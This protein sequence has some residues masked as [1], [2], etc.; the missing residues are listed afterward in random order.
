MATHTNI[1]ELFDD[2]ALELQKQKGSSAKIV[3]DTFPTVISQLPVAMKYEVGATTVRYDA[4]HTENIASNDN[5]RVWGNDEK[6]Y[7]LA[8]WNAIF[9]AAGYDK[10]QMPTSPKGYAFRKMNQ[11]WE[12][13]SWADFFT[14]QLWRLDGSAAQDDKGLQHSPY[15]TL[16]CITAADSGTDVMTNKDWS[17]TADG[18]EWVL[19]AAATKQSFRI[20]KDI[21]YVNALGDSDDFE[22]RTE[23]LYQISEWY[24]HR[25]AIT[26][27]LTTTA[28]NGT[29]GQIAIFN[30]GGEQAAAGEDMYFWIRATDADPWV[31]SEIKAQYNVNNLHKGNATSGL[32]AAYQAT[33]YGA[34][35]TAGID[36]NDTGVNSASKP[37]LA[38]GMKGAEAI[39]VDGYWYIITPYVTYAS[40]ATYQL[41][42]SPAVYWIR[43]KGLSLPSQEAIERWYWNLTMVNAMRTYLNN[44]E[45]WGLPTA[46]NSSYWSSARINVSSAWYVGTSN[47]YRTYNSTTLRN[48]V[49]G[50]S[51][52]NLDL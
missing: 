26:S 52:F 34:Q 13:I 30:A 17:I 29:M 42:D 32:T 1:A 51:G 6:L 44:R 39:A 25:F 19:Y 2:I 7:T 24:R 45:G 10:T 27:G 40:N 49:V 4:T 38:P 31:N 11:K 21:G 43:N 33:L 41:P 50:S 28:A 16:V 37:L 3:A 47:G 12:G 20:P 35:K 9:V 23:S 8:E 14:G 46:E 48:R 36:M 15:N 22:A 5:L 18:D